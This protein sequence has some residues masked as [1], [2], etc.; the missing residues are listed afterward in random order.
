MEVP[1]LRLALQVMCSRP[2][3]SLPLT[4]KTN[5]VSAV[6]ISH[7]PCRSRGPVQD[8]WYAMRKRLKAKGLLGVDRGSWMQMDPNGRCYPVTGV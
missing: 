7:R 2:P 1:T 6:G 5:P 3:E 8:H 4:V